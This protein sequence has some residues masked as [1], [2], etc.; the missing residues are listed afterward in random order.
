METQET[1]SVREPATV[2]QF[3]EAVYLAVLALLAASWVPVSAKVPPGAAEVRP[4]DSLATIQA[5][6]DD[7]GVVYFHPGTYSWTGTLN[8]HN[9]V[10]LTGPE[11][12]ASLLTAS[13]G[14]VSGVASR[15]NWITSSPIPAKKLPSP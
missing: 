10:E 7:G 6:V 15:G 14:T 11:P 8:V 13:A 12:T 4:T 3:P 2:R 1:C 9:S 5:A